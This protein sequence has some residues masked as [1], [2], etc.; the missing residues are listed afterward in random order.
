MGDHSWR[1]KLLWSSSPY[2]TREEQA[3][4]YG[5]QFDD[6]PGFIVK[7]PNQHAGERVDTPFAAV[8][9]RILFDAIMSNQID[10]AE[11]LSLWVATLP[12]KR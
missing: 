5:G 1:T 9:T 7:L 10:S 2:W 6:R 3:A 8:N 4:S 11:E 12:Q